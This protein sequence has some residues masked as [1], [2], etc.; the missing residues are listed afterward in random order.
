MQHVW[1]RTESGGVLTLLRPRA[2]SDWEPGAV[3]LRRAVHEAT[4][5]TLAQ[6]QARSTRVQSATVAESG[7][8]PPAPAPAASAPAAR[9]EPCLLCTLALSLESSAEGERTSASA[10]PLWRTADP[11]R[12]TLQ[13]VYAPVKRLHDVA[14]SLHVSPHL[15][16]PTPPQC[17]KRITNR[18]LFLGIYSIKS[19]L[20]TRTGKLLYSYSTCYY[21]VV[22]LIIIQY[23]HSLNC[24]T[25]E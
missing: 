10:A 7:E 19:S 1:S 21:F 6:L 23:L 20:I 25:Y 24:P 14:F 15:Q 16:V 4:G 11:I 17:I 13:L 8:T 3:Q 18:L 5:C 22:I 12:S 9:V 2:Q